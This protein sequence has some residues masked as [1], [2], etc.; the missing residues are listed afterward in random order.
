MDHRIIRPIASLL[1]GLV[2]GIGLAVSGLANPDKVLQFLTLSEDWS[3]A[4]LFTMAA[5]IVVTA[6]GYRFRPG[7]AG[8]QDG[9]P[10]FDEVFHLPTKKDLDRKLIIGS[11]IFGLGW[12]TAGFCP[13]PAVTGLGTGM[14]EPIIFIVSMVIGSQLQA[15]LAAR[16]GNL[17]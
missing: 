1:S 14:L 16:S 9:R 10:L 13:G 15:L 2:F 8:Q 5:A 6:V 7:G 12:G 17:T 4:L 11:G 3:P